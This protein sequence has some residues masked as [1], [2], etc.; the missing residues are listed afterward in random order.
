MGTRNDPR[1]AGVELSVIIPTFNEREN[2]ARLVCRLDRVLNDIRWEAIF[3]DDDSN[4]GTADEIRS[5]AKSDAR[6]RCLQRIGRRGLSSACIEG[7]LSSSAPFIAVMDADLQHDESIL[8]VMLS[9]LKLSGVDIV[10]GSR[11][12]EGGGLGDWRGHRILI[13]RVASMMSRVVTRVDLKDPMSGFFVIRRTAFMGAVRN[14]STIGF[15]ILLDLFASSP[16]AMTFREVPYQFRSRTAGRSKLDLPAVWGYILLILDKLVGRHVPIRFLSFLIIGGI[17][18][19]VHMIALA[20]A[21]KG[22][23]LSF[24]YS[25]AFATLVSMTFNFFFNN[26]LTYSDL[27]LTGWRMLRGL[28]TFYIACGLGAVANNGAANVIFDLDHR[29]WLAGIVGVM[30]S[31]V[32]N[33][34]VTSIFTWKNR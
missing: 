13:S 33:Y 21:F 11:Y 15:K 9:E 31:A 27:R 16:K 17:G 2:V 23:A 3:V 10:V 34:V 12:I 32:W 24:E 28:F 26:I 7:M 4:D 20:S 22:I 6:V 25:Q 19:G 29:W 30:M 14:L 18:V 8:P 5:I 1:D